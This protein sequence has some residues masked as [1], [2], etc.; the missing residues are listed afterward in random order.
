MEI[1][2]L[3]AYGPWILLKVEKF[4]RVSPGGIYMPEGN[5]EERLGQTFATVLSV[6][7]GKW[8]KKHTA[9]QEPGVK[10]GDQEKIIIP[11][12]RQFLHALNM[13]SNPA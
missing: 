6:G 13:N 2:K 7:K 10:V 5:V 12:L 3:K 9:R 1:E 4:P 8:N 11:E